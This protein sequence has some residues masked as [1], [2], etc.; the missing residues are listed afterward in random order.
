MLDYSIDGRTTSHV[1]GIKIHY[2]LA[3][4]DEDKVSLFSGSQCTCAHTDTLMY[5]DWT[6][7]FYVDI[8]GLVYVQSSAV[9]IVFF[10]F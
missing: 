3:K 4:L 1:H 5:M 10:S 7:R 2:N 8:C 6:Y 9:R